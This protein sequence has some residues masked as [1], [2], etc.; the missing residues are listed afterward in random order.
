MPNPIKPKRSYTPNS[1]PTAGDLQTNELAINW[2]DSK[3]FTKDAS[4]NV[5][6]LTMGGGSGTDTA[7]RAYF[8][9]G[10]PTG[11]TGTA[12]NGQVSLTWTAPSVVAQIP[13]TDYV[14]QYS[15]NSGST[16][17][18]FSDGTSSTASATVTGLTN[19]TAYTFRVAA[20]NGLGTGS[21]STASSA[22]TPVAGDSY[23]ASVKGLFHFDNNATDTSGTGGTWTGSP[24]YSSSTKKFGT[25]ALYPN[26]AYLSRIYSSAYNFGT[27]D[28]CVE[29]WIYPTSSSGIY[30]IYATSGGSGSNPKFVIHLDSL[31]PKVHLSNLSNRTNEW[32]SAGS[33]VTV[34]EWTHIAFVRESG[35]WSWY[36]GGTRTATGSEGATLTFTS[37]STYIAYG[38]ESYF[39]AFA[40]YIDELRI[41]AAARYSGASLTV[42]TAAFPDA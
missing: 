3:L 27:G 4:G 7:L 21:Y 22:V 42:P 2:N 38:G 25:H 39:G 36:L 41:T 5:V 14:V 15:S 28:L 26:G 19:G 11:V 6:T 9:P 13:V 24:S 31:T 29:A 8:I 33:A 1:V 10:A 34:N 37:E 35:T 23:W 17:T 20:T 12:G 18:T 32:I 40:G 30:G 16:W